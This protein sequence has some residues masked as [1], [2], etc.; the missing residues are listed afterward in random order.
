MSDSLYSGANRWGA[1]PLTHTRVT[2]LGLV[3]PQHRPGFGPQRHIT[4]SWWRLRVIPALGGGMS[5]R[6]SKLA[7]A[8]YRVQSHSGVHGA[9]SLKK[10]EGRKEG[11]N[12]Y[13]TAL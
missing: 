5:I 10:Q 6:C 2:F 3:W 4:W 12:A 1:L 7:S 8:F 13:S 11:D 9:L